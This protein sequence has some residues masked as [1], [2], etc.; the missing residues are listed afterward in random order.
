MRIRTPA[1][2]GI[3]LFCLLSG[4]AATQV[5]SEQRESQF[6]V[7]INNIG[8]RALVSVIADLSQLNVI[9]GDEL[10][11]DRRDVRED[12]IGL[13]EL[14]HK[15]VS[16]QGLILKPHHEIFVIGSRCRLRE[17]ADSPRQYANEEP[18][19]GYFQSVTAQAWL[20]VLAE[21]IG[22]PISVADVNA[23]APITLRIK[24]VPATHYLAAMMAVQ[25]W[26]LLEASNKTLKLVPNGKLS[27]CAAPAATPT[28][29]VETALAT[30]AVPTNRPCR[31]KT[32][33]RCM[34]LE[35]YTL[36]E[37][38]LIGY[39]ENL[40]SSVRYAIFST[41]DGP[42]R[43]AK[44]GDYVGTHFGKLEKITDTGVEINE[45]VQEANGEWI[46]Q[47]ET[48]SYR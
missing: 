11:N 35:Y 41:S 12:S 47:R 1:V 23:Q 27:K 9:A 30:T 38:T 44:T 5:I 43:Y 45:L 40:S 37:L 4:C 7:R 10:K 17:L 22:L 15:L 48:L 28:D 14:L 34:P 46:E 19:S 21:R 32:R 3:G 20:D 8:V 29:A 6:R 33:S 18:I 26:S 24:D 31:V 2:V 25:G 13:R 39:V 36:D 16:D 42:V